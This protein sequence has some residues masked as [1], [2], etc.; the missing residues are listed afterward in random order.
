MG[1]EDGDMRYTY[2]SVSFVIR[3]AR[4]ERQLRRHTLRYRLQCLPVVMALV[5]REDK[6][7]VE[8]IPAIRLLKNIIRSPEDDPEVDTRAADTP[9]EIR[10]LSLG[11]GHK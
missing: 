2:P 10:I 7:R 9:E 6:V 5:D 3:N 4:D 8:R 11:R 1:G